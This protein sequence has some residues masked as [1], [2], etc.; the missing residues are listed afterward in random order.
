[1]FRCPNVAN[2]V[3]TAQ[4][5]AQ[6]RILTRVAPTVAVANRA[7]ARAQVGGRSA[8]L[9]MSWD[10]YPFASGRNPRSL[11]RPSVVPVPWI[12]NS[13]QGGII[14][15]CYSIE[16]ITVGTPYFVVVTP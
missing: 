10:E 6:P 12:E 16:G 2:H 15:A 14:S 13:V 11:L 9:G 3:A 1:L 4:A 7:A 8:G 5:S